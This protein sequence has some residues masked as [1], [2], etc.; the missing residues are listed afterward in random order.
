MYKYCYFILSFLLIGCHSKAPL[1]DK[2]G[3]KNEY[4][5]EV[6]NY[7]YETVFYE[8]GNKRLTS[9]LRKWK[10]DLYIIVQEDILDGDLNIVD[11][12]IHQ[13]NQLHLP[14]TIQRTTDIDKANVHIYTGSKEKLGVIFNLAEGT[15]G[16][17]AITDKNGVIDHV[18]IGIINTP[19]TSPYRASIFLEEITQALGIS[20]DSYAYPYSIFYEGKKP[21]T[22]LAPIDKQI[23]TML[24]DKRIP[25]YYTRKTF[26]RDFSEVL[27][28]QLSTQKLKQYIEENKIPKTTLQAI[29]KSC[30]INNVFYKYPK[31]SIV[32][33]TGNYT[34][35]DVTFCQQAIQAL[36]RVSDNLNLQITDTPEQHPYTGVTVRYEKK[37]DMSL[38]VSSTMNTTT[39]MAMLP[40]RIKSD[41]II[42]YKDTSNIQ[43]KK[44]KVLF[45]NIYK[46]L[47]PLYINEKKDS[48]FTRDNNTVSLHNFHKGILSFVYADVFPDGYTLKEFNDL[49]T[50]IE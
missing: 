15:N 31:N 48:L 20:G 22:Q 37:Q 17:A 33:L 14:V 5:T 3:V 19:E 28:T 50:T 8:D 46:A 32:S 24:Y 13:L 49:L 44:N 23:L 4:P 45:E 41:I 39:G 2:E 42:T 47:G 40:K 36:N 18:K 43:Q 12:V 34:A 11:S 29:Q 30:F 10:E 7:F 25:H 1:K 9:H 21:I 6:I 27:H 26:E 16:I 38:S 35:E